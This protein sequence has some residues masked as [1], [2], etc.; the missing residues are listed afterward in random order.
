MSPMTDV[1]PVGTPTD[2]RRTTHGPIALVGGGEHRDATR[3]IDRFLLELS[4]RSRPQ[5]TVVPVASSRRKMPSTAALAR[6]YW[7]SLGASVRFVVP[8][9]TRPVATYDALDAPDLVALTGGFPDRVIGALG[10]SPV[11]DRII[12]LWRSGTGLSGSSAGSMALFDWRLRLLPPD[13]FEL[14]P[15][16]GPLTGYVSLPH[17]D[18]YVAGRPRRRHLLQRVAARYTDRGIVG[19]DEGTALVGWD[20]DLR[21]LGRGAVTVLQ[22]GIWT[23]FP[24]GGQ[25]PIPLL[26]GAERN[27]PTGRRTPSAVEP[28]PTTSVAA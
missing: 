10:I 3:S 4:G 15:G 26:S 11:W 2:G 23:C 8:D 7:T 17:F 22:E 24:G 13:P 21:V 1:R 25:V 14:I 6:S 27:A 18:R 16:L 28:G 20:G 5:V 9:V 12:E 19:L